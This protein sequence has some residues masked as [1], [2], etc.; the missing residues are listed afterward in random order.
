M[1]SAGMLQVARAAQTRQ[2]PIQE[3]VPGLEVVSLLTMLRRDVALLLAAVLQGHVPEKQQE[4]EEL[5][6]V[7]RRLMQPGLSS[8]YIPR[9]MCGV[10]VDLHT[11]DRCPVQSHCHQQRSQEIYIA[12][13]HA[14]AGTHNIAARPMTM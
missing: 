5:L 10:G 13:T 7:R 1:V 2:T 6:A 14:R 3:A 12:I 4:H 9:C 11:R 8:S